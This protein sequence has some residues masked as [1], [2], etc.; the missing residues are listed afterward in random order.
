[1]VLDLVAL[2]VRRPTATA[3]FFL[4][5]VMLGLF[6]WY[7]IPIELM[8]ALRGEQLVVSFV[9]PGSEPEVVEREILLPLEARVGELPGLTETWGEVNGASG[10]LQLQFE[11]GTNIR[12]R[13]LELNSIAAELARTQPEGTFINV[14]SQ[15]LTAFSRFAMIIHVT[16]GADPNALRD[17]VEQRIEPR[18]AAVPGVSQ[19][20]ATGGA[21]REVTVWIDPERC[22]ALGI[23][24][25]TVTALLGR[26]VQRLRFLGGTER[27]GRRWQ[28]TLDGRPGGVA[29]L[30]ELRIDPARPVLLRHVADIEMTTARADSAFRINGADATGLIV[31]QEEGE[32]L[33]RLGRALR[34]R[35]EE[36]RAEWAPY[37]VDFR[38]GFDAAETVEEQLDRLKQLA[39]SGFVIALAV[40][41]LFL[42]ELRAV[43]VVAVAVPM[44]LLIAGA[45]LYLGGYTL[46]LVTLLGLAVG[47]GML[48]DNS[49]VV[50]EA[51]QR[52]LE[53]GLSAESAAIAGIRRT[54][55]AIV[56]AS[57]TNAVVFLPAV[58]LVDDSF[59]RGALELVAIAILLPLFASLVVAVGFVP[60]LAEKFA[61][62]AAAARLARRADWRR[63]HGGK[64]PPQRARALLSAILKSALR[65]PAPW[66]V[67]VT[68]SIVLT[69]VIALPWV[70]VGSLAQQ[71]EQADQVS[72]EIELAG[73]RSLDAA[74][75]V[76]A[77]IEQAV[78][79]LDGIE[80]VESSFQEVGGTLTVH[81]DPAARDA[82]GAT[83]GRV[84]E[85]VRKAVEGLDGV[86]LRTMT[87]DGT[88]GG[89]GDERN[90]GGGGALGGSASEVRVS[91][92]DMVQINLIAREIQSRLE[93][94]PD[95]E[96]AWISGGTGQD[97]LR[98]EPLAA[99]LAAYRLNPEDVLNAL[100]VFRREGVQL[101]VGFTLADGRELPLTVRRPDV[102]AYD[103]LASIDALRLATD[104][105]VVPF[106]VVTT[107]SRVPAPPAIAHHNGRRELSVSYSLGSSA[108]EQG[109]ERLRLESAIEEAVRTVYRPSGYT[110]ESVVDEGT[111]WF[112][113]V[114]VPVLLLL[115]AVLA[116]TFESFTLPILVLVA[117]PLTVLG[118]TWS[119]VLAGVGAGIYAL[120]GV[121]AL[122]GLTVNPAILLVDR[123]QQRVLG[124]GSSGGAAAIA[125]VRERTRPVLMTSAT[126][127]AGLW[128]LA[129]STGQELE[130][131]PPFATVVMGG[132]ATS[133]VLTLVVIPVGFVLLTRIDRIFGKLG[134]WIVL[135]WIA[136]TAAVVA[137]LIVTDRL[138]ALGW[139]ITTTVLVAAALLWLALAIFHRAPKLAFDPAAT[140]IEARYLAKVYGRPGSVK[141]AWRLGRDG[142]RDGGASAAR[143]RRD[144]G[145]RALTFTM[146]FAG[147][148]YLA[149]HLGSMPWR[150]VFAYIAAAFAARAVI[151][152]R[153]AVLPPREE[154]R[155]ARIARGL[156]FDAIVPTLAP[157]IMLA[158]LAVAYMVLPAIDGTRQALPPVAVVV[159]AGLT[160]IVQLGR[161]TARRAAGAAAAGAPADVGRVRAA[162]RQ[163]C[164]AVFGLDLP[165]AEIEALATTSF[166][167]KQGMIGILGPNGAGKTTLLRMLAGVLDPTAG[168]IHY[169]GLPKRRVGG[170]VSRWV[171]YLP[172]E[173]GLPNH[174]TAREYLDYFALL[175]EVGDRQE[176][177]ERVDALLA[178][179]GLD[180][181][182]DE[183]IGAYSGGMRQRVA[184]ARTLLRHPPII[185]VDEPTVGLDPRERI[186]FRNLL[187][188]LAEGRV[189]LFSTHVVEDVA[190]SCR[191]VIVMSRGRIVYDGAPA[192]L[193]GLA[194]GKTWE[195]RLAA[196]E[197]VELPRSCKVVDQVP[198]AG[199]GVRMRVLSATQPHPAAKAIEPVIEDG[200]LELVTRGGERDA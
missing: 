120:V 9:R 167:A 176:R 63:E 175:Y 107:G 18:V 134:P 100:N 96:E 80:L 69:I 70:L 193:A 56:A 200:Y 191:R 189:V 117:V 73:S 161:R 148:L 95:V 49:I 30:G 121:I 94:I 52:F 185:I 15:D 102:V 78:L 150:L 21:P 7:R 155:D 125:A 168:A 192:D 27:D 28:V 198:D 113:L 143:T 62:P 37:G 41:Y 197:H 154:A 72:L 115:Y 178:E 5:L 174:L 87:L 137:P 66:L 151:E 157:W 144:A 65:R 153:L 47:I 112:R 156:T 74:T 173:F 90:G 79:G 35:V 131:W 33:V 179:V 199:G 82:G 130:I 76:F 51:V 19:V 58:F 32:N 105:G 145:E 16:G 11:R 99:A 13:E 89:S 29:S 103:A 84:R 119:L 109:P 163:A 166:A 122:L 195:I 86:E 92:P 97:E 54:V 108:P 146:L 172:Q 34:E 139:Q 169:S 88:G 55:R 110:V 186:R 17:L 14:S 81:L 85:E 42:R 45:M 190:V 2:P 136:A 158:A 60:L 124:S 6:A 91:G 106:G 127:I 132:L 12:V 114:F 141:R 170:Y 129:L 59:I 159:L 26:S 147:A 165:R 31:F 22:A 149:T 182:K 1:M 83:A 4:A 39:L 111:D 126:T 93:S 36:L 187:S 177:R 68:V 64:P 46:N 183:K 25:E 48:V 50:F 67:A 61:A 162:W 194:A 188:R 40:L 196:G 140:A 171:G 128:P 53:R 184:V 98:V 44:S 164:L 180:E 77:R 57:A 135:G 118:A 123:M 8:P 20:L 104:E 133:T 101:Q 10:R 160:L 181:R 43:A 116:I 75:S 71:A 138:N 24:P 152:L 23:R 38:I 142:G 3:M